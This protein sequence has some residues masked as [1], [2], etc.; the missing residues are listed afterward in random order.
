MVGRSSSGSAGFRDGVAALESLQRGQLVTVFRLVHLDVG[1]HSVWNSTVGFY[2]HA[3]ALAKHDRTV[4]GELVRTVTDDG[5]FVSGSG[6]EVTLAWQSIDRVVEKNGF[7]FFF[8]SKNM[9][10]YIPTR[11][12]DSSDDLTELRRLAVENVGDRAKVCADSRH[13]ANIG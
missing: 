10:Y 1:I 3:R 12:L 5:F 2:S 13:T 6:T 4:Q 7:M 8:I 9:A 11:T